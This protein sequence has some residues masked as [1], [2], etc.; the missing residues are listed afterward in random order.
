[1]T[2]ILDIIKFTRS[3]D[4]VIKNFLKE[5]KDVMVDSRDT[6]LDS[7][8]LVRKGKRFD[9]RKFVDEAIKNGAIL[10]LTERFIKDISCDQIVVN[11]ILA[12]ENKI[13]NLV[14]NNPSEE[15]SVY[16]VT[17]TNGKT[18]VC[19]ILQQIL[20][21][22]NVSTGRTGTIDYDTIGNIYTSV[23]TFPQGPMFIRL[24]RETIQN[25]GRAF[26]SEVSSHAISFGR[27]DSI[28]FDGVIFT[29]LTREHLDFHGSMEEYF[30]VK[31]SFIR[32][33][34][35]NGGVAA[36]NNDDEYGKKI[37][38]E[39]DGQDRVITYGKNIS[40]DLRIRKIEKK[41]NMTHVEIIFNE[42]R[43][44]FK[45]RL[46]GEFNVYNIVACISLLVVKGAD[47]K[48]VL[49]V[50]DFITPPP[51]RMEH[52]KKD[53]IDVF[54]DYAHTP[55]A[56]E[57]ALKSLKNDF[58]KVLVVF[59]CG[60]DRDGGKRPEM[61]SVAENYSDYAVVTSDNPRSE[62]PEKIAYDIIEG[63][64]KKYYTLILDRK[65]AIQH[66][67]KLCKEEGYTLLIAGKGH[68]EY[69]ELKGEKIFLSDRE[70]VKNY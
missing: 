24:L 62:Q 19:Y 54:I 4:Y 33:C 56:L 43:F 13:A 61:G 14:Y 37:I 28:E 2:R 34:V 66:A 22:L 41:E 31:S 67:L 42:K 57:N 9:G 30:H 27:V 3:N 32:R 15:I 44:S 21:K 23:N 46:I 8:F 20:Q 16:S 50:I 39:F 36:I 7:V 6:L 45:T 1:M 35:I 63:M 25:G 51:G 68:E 58:E 47:I 5:V 65:E 18:S 12:I 48:S 26:V 10:I 29:N 59:G 49:N 70:I 64:P 53:E 38:K 69:Q 11:N 60:G 55:D 52:I 40:S 17:G